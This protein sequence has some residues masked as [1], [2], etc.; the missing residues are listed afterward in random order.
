VSNA[1]APVPQPAHSDIGASAMGRLIACPA[2]YGLTLQLRAAGGATGGGSSIYAAT[3]TVA[4]ALAEE[5][6]SL[7]YDP[8]AE[9]GTVVTVDGHD[10]TV[11]QSMIDGVRVYLD[12]VESLGAGA[13]IKALETR[14]CLDPYWRPGE[15]QPPVSA[16]GTAD[17]WAYHGNTLHL[18]V[19]DYKNG[20]GVFVSAENNPQA[21]YY[22]AGV[23]LELEMLGLPMP[24][25]VDITIVQPN[26]RG[27][28]KVRSF[29]TSVID[30]Q[31]WVDG[32]LKPTVAEILSPS[33]R[34][35]AGDHCKFCPARGACPALA[36]IR[37]DL[38]RRDFGPSPAEPVVLDADE[39]GSVLTDV[40][41]VDVHV[42][43]LREQAL[44]DIQ[45]GVPVPGWEVVPSR[46]MRSW[47]MPARDLRTALQGAGFDDAADRIIAPAE[48]RTPAQVEKI[49]TPE[50]WAILQPYVQSK[51]S[52]VRLVPSPP[53]P[54]AAQ[55]GGTRKT[56]QDDFA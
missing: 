5:A 56:A 28:D 13:T 50:E 16:F 3:G 10:V 41:L 46:P 22:V 18:D 53:D 19:A 37:Q 26:F 35:A 52:G 48:V 25:T 33:P 4:H 44:R 15:P 8:A 27:K 24:V 54:L 7:G 11:D 34:M 6:V 23:L 31:M 42:E 12:T 55:G 30:I 36:Q 39:L 47:S 38:A 21:H 2:S 17:F 20:A 43:A 29:A 49:L 45:A 9:L 51:S 40:D 32:V 14:V 1:A